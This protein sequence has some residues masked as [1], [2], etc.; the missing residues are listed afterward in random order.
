MV[1]RKLKAIP[2]P[3][4]ICRTHVDGLEDA[5][6]DSLLLHLKLRSR[7][8]GCS[9]QCEQVQSD[10][11]VVSA[12]FY[13]LEC[14]HYCGSHIGIEGRNIAVERRDAAGHTERL[15]DLAAQLVRL[16]LDLI[17]AQA[18]PETDAAKRATNSIPIVFLIHGDPVGIGHVASLARP[19]GN[20][21]GTGGFFPDL[22]AK[23]LELLKQTLPRL[24]R[25]A[26]LWNGGNPIKHLDWKAVQEAGRALALTLQ[27]WEVKSVGDFPGI[28]DTI[29]NGSR[30][31]ALI[32]LEDPVMFDHR[33]AIVEFAD[34]ERL[35]A[36]YGLREFVDAGG[37]MSYG[38]DLV[39]VYRRGAIKVDKILKGA[40]PA[41]LP[42]EQ[43]TKFEL[44][45]NFKTAKALGLTIPPSVLGRAD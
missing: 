9:S 5:V 4:W 24:T 10:S 19:G 15:P 11:G 38:Y 40:K 18:G 28:F 16:N 23:R 31:E 30:A 34:R 25:V 35:P 6:L 3:C 21:T 44:V 26:V 29:R 2:S 33:A 43:P 20:V 1:M 12:R 41:G 45:I 22:A 42:V 17:V 39:E 14:H 32:L 13:R 36:I 7:V 37:L 8:R 27:S